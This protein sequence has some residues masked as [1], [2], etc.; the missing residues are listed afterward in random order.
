MARYHF[1]LKEQNAKRP[2]AYKNM[3][4]SCNMCTLMIGENFGKM[5]HEVTLACRDTIQILEG[6]AKGLKIYDEGNEA[7]TKII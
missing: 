7:L 2:I 6:Q 5:D 1:R 4:S 3:F